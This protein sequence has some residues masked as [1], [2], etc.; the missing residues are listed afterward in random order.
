MLS[1]ES[2][3]PDVQVDAVL[4]TAARLLVRQ[5]HV[6]AASILANA[7]CDLSHWS[8]D[9]WNGGQD[10]WQ[11]SLAVPPDVYFDM[12]GREEVEG[13]INGALATAMQ[14]LSDSDCTFAKIVTLLDEDPDWRL[15]VRQHLSGEGITNQG[16]VRSDNIAARQH[17][18]LLFRSRP[19]VEFYTALKAT[20]LP[21]APL[22][23]VLRGG[24]QRQR[25]EPDFI[26]IKNGLVMI[27]EI[28]GDLYHTETPAAAHARLKFL[29]D[30]GARLERINA[31]E[32]DTAEK[33][34][35]A[36]GRV[37]ATMDKLR[38]VL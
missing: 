37:I 6:E 33:A 5:Q 25:V 2:T 22:A 1:N 28:D 17:D 14:A 11:L 13:Q 3:F 10:T 32:C 12:K 16:R 7:D 8:H 29:L 21:F 31:S 23:V 35:E 30:E 18:G 24:L 36:V 9:N 20:G 26:V 4:A 15:K 27:V 38:G 34:R 19:E